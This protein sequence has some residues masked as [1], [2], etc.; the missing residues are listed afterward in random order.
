[1]PASLPYPARTFGPTKPRNDDTA[2]RLLWKIAELL[3]VG[4]GGNGV[5][6][7]TGAGTFTGLYGV[8]HAL[9]DTVVAS[10]TYSDGS[11]FPAGSTVKAGDQIAGNI[12][13]IVITSG[14][15]ELYLRT[16]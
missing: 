14:T 12:T 2:Q 8:Y 6:A 13:S 7:V 3:S 1:M 16:V 10:V 9:T 15:G 11:T 4:L 5:E